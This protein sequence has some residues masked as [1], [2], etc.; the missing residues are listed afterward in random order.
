MISYDLH[1][2][3]VC[4]WK[5]VIHSWEG[6]CRTLTS[7]EVCKSEGILQLQLRITGQRLLKPI[8]IRLKVIG[9]QCFVV[10]LHELTL[11]Y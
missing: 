11:L 3:C 10:L 1:V 7:A 5:T 4:N 6:G 9:Q 8:T 2:C